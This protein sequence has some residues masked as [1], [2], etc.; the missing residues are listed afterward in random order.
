MNELRKLPSVEKINQDPEIE[1]YIREYG[2]NC[3]ISAIRDFLDFF[4]N[5]IKNG[6]SAPTIEGVQNKIFEIL[7]NQFSATLIPVINA[8]GVVLHTNLGRAPLS[9]D[10]IQAMHSIGSGYNTLEFNLSTGKR[11]SRS[12]HAEEI[13]KQL[14]GTEA[15]LIVNNNAAAVLLVLSALANRKNVVIARSQ[16]IEIGGGFRIPDVMK[17]SGAKLLEVGTTN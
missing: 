9:L 1:E 4:R 12:V 16:L 17:Q 11:G 13:L 5:Q 3:V 10:T 7:S 2:R 8:T 14:T 15:A 6:D